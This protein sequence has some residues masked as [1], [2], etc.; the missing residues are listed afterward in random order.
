MNKEIVLKKSKEAIRVL[1][2]VLVFFVVLEGL[3]L[4]LFSPRQ[5]KG[6]KNR[7]QDAYSFMDEQKDTIQIAGFGNS[8]LYSA[9]SPL[10]LWKSFGYTGTVCASPRQ[11]IQES[12]AF[13]Q[14]VF[15][16]QSP[17]V[18]I[19][20]TDMFYDEKPKSDKDLKRKNGLKFVFDRMN[21]DFFERDVE[22]IFSVFKFH[23]KWK[24]QNEKNAVPVAKTHGYRYN[25]MVYDI[26][27]IDYMK[28]TDAEEPISDIN[29]QQMDKFIELCKK[30]NAQILFVEMPAVASWNYERHN[31]VKKYADSRGIAFLDINLL[32]DEVGISMT[33]CFRDMGNHLNY[34]SARAVT[35]YIG[36]FIK[37]NYDIKPMNSPEVNTAWQ[38]NYEKFIKETVEQDKIEEV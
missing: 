21:P 31:A 24:T 16:N 20:E 2:F 36:K 10:D 38:E 29:I 13:A 5:A 8:D 17:K 6:F 26:K 19:I 27:P 32:Y 9:F 30:N 18:V 34:Y 23:S 4:T 35:Q 15:E 1:A 3:S 37:E 22:N 33:N 25:N 28:K 12:R 14:K 7:L 11:T